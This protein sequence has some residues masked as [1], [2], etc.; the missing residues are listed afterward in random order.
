MKKTIKLASILLLLNLLF[1]LLAKAES[2]LEIEY[3]SPAITNQEINLEKIKVIVNY[4][5]MDYQNEPFP[6]DE[7]NLKY[8]IYYDNQLQ[9]NENRSTINFGKIFLQD[10]NNN[11]IPEVIVQ[12]Y[13]GG[14]HCCTNYIIYLWQPEQQQF[15]TLETG[16][17]EGFG[18]TFEDLD[19]DGTIEF[20]SVDNNFYYA[21]APY[22]ASYP[23]SLI[24]TL[25]NNE[26]KDVT[27]QYP[28]HLRGAA[29]EMFKLIKESEFNNGILAGYVA[30]KILLGEF[31]EGWKFMLANYNR[32]LD[33]GLYIYDQESNNIIG[34]YPDFPTA[35][36]AF[37]IE[38]GY[39]NQEG[40]P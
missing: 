31:E 28:E 29:W 40:Q 8:Q 22:A 39:L 20:I 7:N 25:E 19:Q 3:D 23:P 30:Q 18:G 35:L 38:T 1:N 9:I 32:E 14:A 2:S 36:K 12:T 5:P 37:L 26:F 27:T 13:S 17:L 24:L 4:Q 6:L 21:F 10:L 11:Q 15:K 34:K 16:E 33:W